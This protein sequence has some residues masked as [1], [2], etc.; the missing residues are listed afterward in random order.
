MCMGTPSTAF[1]SP[2]L[3]RMRSRA[4]NSAAGNPLLAHAKRSCGSRRILKHLMRAIPQ[5]QYLPAKPAD[6]GVHPV[7]QGRSHRPSEELD[8]PLDKVELLRQLG[9]RLVPAWPG[10]RRRVDKVWDAKLAPRCCH[11]L[12]VEEGGGPALDGLDVWYLGI[13]LTSLAAVESKT[14]A[15]CQSA[16]RHSLTPATEAIS[17]EI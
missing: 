4:A 13:P 3:A 17:E 9:D 1:T 2:D 10:H 6:D 5:R 14:A 8:P 12:A 16:V 11:V 7:Q 15:G